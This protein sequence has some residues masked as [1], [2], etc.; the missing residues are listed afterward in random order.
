MKLAEKCMSSSLP[1][2][3]SLTTNL[4]KSG[5]KHILKPFF[6]SGAEFL[7]LPLKDRLRWT[8]KLTQNGRFKPSGS[9]FIFA[10]M[11]SEDFLGH[12]LMKTDLTKFHVVRQNFQNMGKMEEVMEPDMCIDIISSAMW[13]SLKQCSIFPRLASY[14]TTERI[15]IYRHEGVGGCFAGGQ[16]PF[17]PAFSITKLTVFESQRWTAIIVIFHCHVVVVC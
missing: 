16:V 7:S 12:Q 1:L 15:N 2:T 17:P 8:P 6:F 3:F 5:N 10:G 9:L 14:Q 11:G 13:I 4:T